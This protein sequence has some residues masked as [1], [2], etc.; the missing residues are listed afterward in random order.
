M[1]V[2][3]TS[4]EGVAIHYPFDT[5]PEQEAELAPPLLRVVLHDE[6]PEIRDVS[7]A[8]REGDR[9]EARLLELLLVSEYLEIDDFLGVIDGAIEDCEKRRGKPEAESESLL[10]LVV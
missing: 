1:P 10:H 5:R 7:A 6:D 8:V 2:S 3:S 9:V 4:V